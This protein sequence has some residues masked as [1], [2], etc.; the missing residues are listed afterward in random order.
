MS[1]VTIEVYV[2][3]GD[4]AP[5]EDAPAVT[6]GRKKAAESVERSFRLPVDVALAVEQLAEQDQRSM[7]NM[8]AVLLREALTARGVIPQTA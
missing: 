7:N 4:T 6:V 3:G 5:A 8:A 2:G 1:K